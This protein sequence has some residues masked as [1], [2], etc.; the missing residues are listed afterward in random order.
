[1]KALLIILSITPIAMWA[2]L[3]APQVGFIQDSGNTLRPVYGLAGN[4]I[5]GDPVAANMESASFS[6]LFG[7]VKTT[8]ALVV[9][10]RQGQVVAS[11]DAAAGPALFAFSR[12]GAP[13][14]AYLPN[15][16]ALLQW[17]DGVFQQVPLDPQTT[18]VSIAAVDPGQ[19]AFI[20]Q[21][22]DGLWDVRILLS[23]GEVISQTAI[24]GVAAPALMLATG[25]LLYGDANGIVLRRPDGSE[26]HI[27]AQL[28]PTF[29]FQQMGD[30]WIQVR[31]L[32]TQQQ[33]AVRLSEG[34][35]QFY[36]LP[37]VDQ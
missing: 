33:Y 18:V 12:N 14:L 6:G 9:V 27:D 11:Q 8:S 20:L 4:F 16:N 23:T 7:I 31:D 2:Q 30:G 25:E 19:A 24:V 37:G 21:R 13:A 28:P 35:E 34:K 32:A 36:A 17:S 15:A 3:A 22:D 5:L 1:M 29:A 10:D 26:K